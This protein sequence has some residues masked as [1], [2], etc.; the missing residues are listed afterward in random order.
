M[1][2]LNFFGTDFDDIE[3]DFGNHYII[4]VT[5]QGYVI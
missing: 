1:D 3:H 4:N 2:L 5:N